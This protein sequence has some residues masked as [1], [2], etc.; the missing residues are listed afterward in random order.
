MWEIE[1][2]LDRW[3]H[4]SL[5]GPGRDPNMFEA[6]Y[7]K[8]GELISNSIWVSNDHVTDDVTW[9]QKGQGRD[10]DMFGT[11]YL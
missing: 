5:K 9:P 11:E 10:L 4:V 8:N 3:R 7:L 6:H 1:S 2:S